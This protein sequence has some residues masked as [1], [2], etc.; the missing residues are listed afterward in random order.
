MQDHSLIDNDAFSI[1]ALI[2]A[3]LRRVSGRVVDA[4]YLA[5]NVDYAHY[6]IRLAKEAADPELLRLTDRLARKL[7]L[8]VGQ[9]FTARMPI[10]L[11]PKE[12]FICDEPTI[13]DIEKA[14]GK[15]RY[16]GALR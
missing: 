10:E 1:A 13:E 16:I 12:E 15:N 2:Y 6:V 3:R 9:Q 7:N 11:V 5:E 8:V 14:Q 4:L